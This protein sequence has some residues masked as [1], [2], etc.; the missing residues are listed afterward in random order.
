V[1]IERDSGSVVGDIG[2]KATRRE[3][4]DRGGL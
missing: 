1:I 2:F 3:P 4:F